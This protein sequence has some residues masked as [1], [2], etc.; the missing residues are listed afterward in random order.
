[1]GFQ[2]NSV[3]FSAFSGPTPVRLTLGSQERRLKNKVCIKSPA[4]IRASVDQLAPHS[5]SQRPGKQDRQLV[6]A[7]QSFTAALTKRHGKTDDEVPTL[8]E[9]SAAAC[10]GGDF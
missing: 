9:D 8:L 1:M 2:S 5:Q 3:P 4:R 10:G 6:A 7:S